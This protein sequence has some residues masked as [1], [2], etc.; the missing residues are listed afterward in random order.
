M[1][2][3]R[4]IK[5][6]FW[7]DEKV[8]ELTCQ[9]RLMFIGCWNLADDEG[10]LKLNPTYL[11]SQI[12]P[13]DDM[14]KE[15]SEIALRTIMDAGMIF[16]YKD[17]KQQVYGW[18]PNFRKH[19]RI[20]KP[21]AAKHPLPSL[22]NPKIRMQYAIRDDFICHICGEEIILSERDRSKVLSLDHLKPA[23]KGGVDA[24]TNIKIAH[25]GC[26]ASKKDKYDS[27]K[28][29]D[30]SCIN[31]EGSENDHDIF[32]G[33]KERKGKE[34]KGEERKGT[35]SAPPQSTE[36]DRAMEVFD[37]WVFVMKKTGSTKLTADRKKLITARL[38]EGYSVNDI[39]QAI[40]G[41]S[42][43]PHNMGINDRNTRYNGLEIICK[44]GANLERFIENAINP[45]DLS[46]S[47]KHLQHDAASA[48]IK[49][50]ILNGTEKVINGNQHAELPASV[51]PFASLSK[52][53]VI[54]HDKG[55]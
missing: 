8:G 34:R 54:E 42:V 45:P 28:D 10:L 21:Q 38:K 52:T 25:F 33:G 24:P 27:G 31:L 17:Q 41:C 46:K 48:A 47:A 35:M 12:F 43:T 22:Q 20:D 13:Y 26:N 51:L 23:S 30:D 14:S 3:I 36:V 16:P 55:N 6:E 19:Q 5:P 4:T 49:D 50:S 2:R 40:N 18:I 32:T 29:L 15:E 7:Q 39:K 53:N 11:K 44:N 9:A 37:H 1:A